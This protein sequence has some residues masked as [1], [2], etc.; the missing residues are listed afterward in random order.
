MSSLQAV[1]YLNE[2]MVKQTKY[3]HITRFTNRV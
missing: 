3:E 1:V 2:R